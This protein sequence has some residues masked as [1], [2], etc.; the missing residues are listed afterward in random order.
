MEHK[1]TK[2]GKA[3]ALALLTA[4]LIGV[5]LFYIA[6]CDELYFTA[7]DFASLGDRLLSR[8]IP[9]GDY[10]IGQMHNGRLLGNL[11]GVAE[12][13]LLLSPLGWLRAFLFAGLLMA[14][15]L[16]L[17]K[18]G[19]SRC[20]YGLPAALV[21]VLCAPRGVYA[22]VYSWGV[23]FVNYLLPMLGFL[24][25]RLLLQRQADAGPGRILGLFLLALF[26]QLFVETFTISMCLYGLLL[27]FRRE[28][29][30]RLRA[31]A[32]GGF[33]LGA[34][35]MFLNPEYRTVAQGG[36]IY[37]VG[38]SW[39]KGISAAKQIC[40]ALVLEALP[41]ALLFSGLLAFRLQR[42]GKAG[43]LVGLL[44]LSMWAGTD[45][46]LVSR[47]AALPTM[48]SLC[49]G[50][51]FLLSWLLSLLLLRDRALLELLLIAGASLAPLLV[52]QEGLAPRMYF[53]AYLLL[54]LGVLK[55]LPQRVPREKLLHGGL[56]ALCAFWLAGML[57]IYSRNSA[58]NRARLELGR[59]ELERGAVTLT[60]PLVPYPDYLTNEHPGKGDLGF[61]LFRDTP[62]DTPLIFVPYES[63]TAAQ[64]QP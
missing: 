28:L 39:A 34:L 10:V 42:E 32:F 60:L 37:S 1:S 14:L 3:L 47:R 43:W 27:L 23:A 4:L 7:W 26:T 6:E 63:W 25:C 49:C 24:L 21:L 52:L 33:L 59:A 17:Q 44:L 58:V 22:N 62:L 20:A 57:Y 19:A 2:K 64:A 5:N 48:A 61:L 12:A 16:L 36:A 56:L 13:K 40:Q 46:W 41:L 30:L 54:G 35:C 53:E 51:L 50:A 29:P 18:T 38:L 15:A 11:L 55:L 45:L 9:K 8:P 31:A